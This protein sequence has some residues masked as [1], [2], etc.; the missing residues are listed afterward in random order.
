VWRLGGR[1]RGCCGWWGALPSCRHCLGQSATAA[2]AAAAAAGNGSCLHHGLAWG[3]ESRCGVH[4]YGANCVGPC[5]GSVGSYL[6]D[7]IYSPQNYHLVQ[8]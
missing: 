3:L 7:M 1:L 8:M 2:A 4:W 5:A 6:I